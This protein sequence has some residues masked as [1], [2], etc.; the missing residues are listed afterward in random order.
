MHC[1]VLFKYTVY[2]AEHIKTSTR[3]II[4]QKEVFPR[5]TCLVN[6]ASKVDWLYSVFFLSSFLFLTETLKFS[7]GE[8]VTDLLC[9]EQ[10]GCSDSF[11]FILK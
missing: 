11:I 5:S 7:S 10:P 4:D 9:K 2:R 1:N 3:A 8:K 6:E